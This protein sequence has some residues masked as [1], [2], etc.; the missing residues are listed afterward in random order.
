MASRSGIRWSLIGCALGAGLALGGGLGV[1]LDAR[2][3]GRAALPNPTKGVGLAEGCTVLALD[4]KNGRTEA[5]PCPAAAQQ[6]AAAFH[7]P[8]PMPA[9]Y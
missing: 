2:A 6:V 9:A 4:R 7:S 8:R 3:D 5:A 1:L